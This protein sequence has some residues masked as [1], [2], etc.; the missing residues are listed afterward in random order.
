MF[1]IELITR[2]G[3]IREGRSYTEA[4]DA[5][6]EARL[7]SQERLGEVSVW[8]PDGELHSRWIGGYA[9]T[10]DERHARIS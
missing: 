10:S 5:D 3:E 7:I 9:A 6:T 8:A 1:R 2:T 4:A